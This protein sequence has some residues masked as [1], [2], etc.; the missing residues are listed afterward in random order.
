MV[1]FYIDPMTDAFRSLP[2]QIPLETWAERSTLVVE[3]PR[4]VSRHTVA[5]VNLEGVLYALK[6]LPAG[7][8]QNEQTLLRQAELLR[9]PVVEACGYV[10]LEGGAEVLVTRYLERSLPYRSIFMSQALE[11]Y[12]QSLVD[13]MA[14]LLV[15]LHLGG[16]YW[17]D[18]SLSNT[19]FRRD[20]GILQAYLVDAESSQFH[21]GPLA[22]DLRLNDLETMEANVQADL[23]ELAA[24][25][26]LP[27]GFNYYD[28]GAVIRRKYQL[29]WDFLNR[30]DIILPGETY[31]IAERVRQLNL[32]GFS[33]R[34]VQLVP[35]AQGDQLRLKIS[36]ADRS[37]Y[38]DQLSDLTGMQV[39]EM[40][41]RTLMNEIEEMRARLSQ[42]RGQAVALDAA[43]FYW[44]E[45]IYKPLM[46]DLAPLAARRQSRQNEADPVLNTDA[47]EL[48]CQVLEHKWFLS[49]R[50]QA[51][52]G[53]QAALAD[54][55]R[56]FG[57]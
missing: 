56:Q 15:R 48:Y 30:V 17:G 49:E 42:E 52:V 26:C 53:H 45:Q 9:F 10:L 6:E 2:W 35:T 5:F 13:A 40:Q 4:G 1:T 16:F 47:T 41:A 39:E 38:R 27:E 32:M 23:S 51:N 57:E 14:G 36:V 24:D 21:P 8:G 29:L 43:A 20:A 50:A 7:H 55:L 18:C 33:A 34:D 19:L 12:R 44:Q 46:N 31:R 25:N 54:Y 3:L 37:Y 22:P 28:T 11:R